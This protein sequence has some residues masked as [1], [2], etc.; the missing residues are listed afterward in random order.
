MGKQQVLKTI[1]VADPYGQGGADSVST[2]VALARKLKQRPVVFLPGASPSAYIEDIAK[3][4]AETVYYLN[5]PFDKTQPQEAALAGLLHLQRA[6]E[7]DVILFSSSD[8]GAELAARAAARFGV[9]LLPDLIDLNIDDEGKKLLGASLGF[10]GALICWKSLSGPGPW[11]ATISQEAAASGPRGEHAAKIEDLSLELGDESCKVELARA[12]PKPTEEM[13][14]LDR[15]EVVVAG[16][17]GVEGEAGFAMLKE[18]ALLLGGALGCTLPP[19]EQGYMDRDL[20]VGATGKKV[21][22]KCYIACG[23][24][25]DAYHTSGMDNS[26]NIVVINSDKKAP[27]YKI[28][29]YGIVGDLHEIVPCII[30][31]LKE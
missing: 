26:E 9:E 11:I 29:D 25:G 10:K 24:S 15:A 4:G 31:K 12:L 21:R 5:H 7:A 27:F 1:I 23:I 8:W 17:Q 2:L 13:P 16:G 19:V 20:M 3:S 6:I 14:C 22:A 18:L 30:A 28:A